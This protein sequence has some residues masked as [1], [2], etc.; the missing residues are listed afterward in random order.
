M[1]QGH[2][3]TGQPGQTRSQSS[4][5]RSP[6]RPIEPVREKTVFT[7]KALDRNGKTIK[8]E[9]AA[10]SEDAAIKALARKS[11]QVYQIKR[12][13]PQLNIQL[14]R[15][16]ITDTDLARFVRQLAT[17]L[18]AGVSMLDAMGSLAK[19]DSHAG[20]QQAASDI[21]RD[22][23]AGQRLSETLEA[24]LPGLPSYVARLAELGEATGQ[25]K[26][27][28]ADAAERMEFEAAMRSEVRTA[29]TYPAF[30]SI[31]GSLLVILL[32]VFVVPRFDTLIGDRDVDIPAFSEAILS[33]G[34]W[35]SQNLLT[36][37]L[38]IT[39]LVMAIVLA[40]RSDKIRRTVRAQAERLPGIG[41]LLIQSDLGGW[42]KTVGI[43]LSNG[44][45]LLT[46]LRLGEA[47]VASDRLVN[48]FVTLR[49]KVRSGEDFDVALEESVPDFDGL[50]ID[51]IRTGRVSGQL[52]DMLLFIGN[53]EEDRTRT[54]AKRFAALAE[55]I[56]ILTI[57]AII[58]AIVISIVLAM[59]S[60]YDFSI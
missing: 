24:R 53:G 21:R 38:I 4:S 29:L 55:P 18:G 36:F 60:V 20:L 46:A 54:R 45:D 43:A 48:G 41:P 50:T 34:R 56:A 9:V 57:S 49:A 13:P 3:M 1:Q 8:G 15:Q 52:A 14:G 17:L 12:Q 31:V 2:K 7:Y 28:L 11:Q 10:L 47:G 25:S 16:R 42:A 22:L 26:Q 59:T 51:L 58:G 23:R 39:G 32:F 6:D 35:M 40:R 30:L 5:T 27:A 33:A 44:A 19:S 37:G